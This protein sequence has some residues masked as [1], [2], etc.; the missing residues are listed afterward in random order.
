MDIKQVA[1]LARL[2]VS[3][4]ELAAIGKQ[5]SAILDYI[6]QLNELNTD[7]IEPMAHPL[8][9]KNVFRADEHIESLSVDETLSNAP[10]RIGD[11]FGVPAVM[12]PSEEMT[13]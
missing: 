1:K 10:V 3:D 4:D 8:P 9:I 13:S 7:G 11:F 2:E 12:D 5:L 6:D